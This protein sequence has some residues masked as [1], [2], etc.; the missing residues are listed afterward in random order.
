MFEQEMKQ[1]PVELADEI[2]MM[3]C[4]LEDKFILV[5]GDSDKRF[6]NTLQIS[7]K[8]KYRIY[9][10]AKIDSNSNK[11]YVINVL[12]LLY[13]RNIEANIIGIVDADYD[14]LDDINVSLKSLYYYK[15]K[16][17]ELT[18][19]KSPSLD[20]VNELV[21]SNKK[22]KPTYELL[23]LILTKT[24][25]LGILR[26]VNEKYNY[27]FDFKDIKFKKLYEKTEEDFLKYFCDYTKLPFDERSILIE[28]YKYIKNKNYRKEYICNGHDALEIFSLLLK[29]E[30]ANESHCEHN[31]GI[32]CEMLMSSYHHIQSLESHIDIE[33]FDNIV[34][35]SIKT[36]ELNI[37]M[38]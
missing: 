27:N 35:S 18:L 3:L 29:Q 16:D 12:K 33:S 25:P 5:E 13:E 34:I 36:K 23:E 32:L 8:K 10:G 30:I 37:L 11:D 6:W 28:R 31:G 21:S 19:L 15:Y 2:G 24:Y 14:F 9:L 26:L 22:R 4:G 20:I 7:N 38:T 1:S 17:L